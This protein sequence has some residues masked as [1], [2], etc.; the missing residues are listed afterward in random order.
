MENGLA[1]DF[2]NEAEVGFDN[3]KM[4]LK[5]KGKKPDRVILD[6]SFKGTAKPGRMVRILKAVNDGEVYGV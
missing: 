5:Q 4:V 2:L 6:G 1:A 3:I